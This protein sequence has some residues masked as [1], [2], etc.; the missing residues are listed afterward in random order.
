MAA[1]SSAE[2]TEEATPKRLREARKKGQV[3]KSKDLTTIFEL[4]GLF[5]T[6][7]VSVGYMGSELRALM[8]KAFSLAGEKHLAGSQIYDVGKACLLTMAK[9][10]AP[11]LLVGFLMALFVGFMQ[12]GPMFSM[13]TLK[14]QGK[15]LNPIE[16]IKNMFKTLTFIELAKNILKISFIFFIS[17]KILFASLPDILLTTRLGIYESTIY[18]GS[19]IFRI[20]IRVLILFVGIAIADYMV[21]RWQFM[22]QMRMSKDEVKREYKQDEG[23]PH[24]KAH[25]KA[26]H[27][28]M[29]F[30]DVQKQVK[31]SDVVVTNPTHVAVAIKYDRGEMG[32]PEI[33]AAGH[34]LFAEMIKKIAEEN[35]IPIMR[36]VPLAWSLVEL[37]VGDEIP[38]ELYTTVAEILAIVYKMKQEQAKPRSEQKTDYA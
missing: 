28:E 13:E 7:C 33:M 11:L 10:C 30:S 35:N 19:V 14:P 20:V 37:E 4:L 17:Y 22:K 32:A 16:G 9:V 6:F 23:D 34:R 27:R 5:I 3:A 25:R 38:E 15:K 1:D 36:N 24:I 31:A 18:A 12:V 8:I 21:Q 2:K 26:L 29:I